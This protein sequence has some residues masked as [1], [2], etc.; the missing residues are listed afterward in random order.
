MFDTYAEDS[1]SHASGLVKF[2]RLDDLAA[3][4]MMSIYCN[5][6]RIVDQDRSEMKLKLSLG[7]E[8]QCMACR[9]ARI[10]MEIDEMNNHFDGVSSEEECYV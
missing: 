4:A 3:S 7:K 10:S 6:G 5:C 9:N 2:R 1:V 8:L